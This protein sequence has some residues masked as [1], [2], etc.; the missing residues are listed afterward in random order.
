MLGRTFGRYEVKS[1]AGHDGHN[2]YWLCACSCGQ[3][4]TVAQQHLLSGA[5][6]SCG[7]LRREI[8]REQ[9]TVHGHAP[10][11]RQ[12]PTYRAW[13]HMLE[14]CSNPKTAMYQYYGGRGITVCDQWQEFACFLKDM[15]ER[16]DG[17]TIDRKDNDG[18]YE[19]G[20]CRWAT[21][22]EQNRNRRS[23][24]RL[25]L[26]GETMCATDWAAR[27]GKDAATILRRYHAGWPIEMVLSAKRLSRWDTKKLIDRR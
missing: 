18:H 25:T 10:A 7:C 24:I 20:N 3:S 9:G 1:H 8:A 11:K 15:G 13:C 27:L 12:T 16:P 26:D 21:I 14:R 5:S 6:K 4:R 22:Q 19:P 23:N 17:T 2:H